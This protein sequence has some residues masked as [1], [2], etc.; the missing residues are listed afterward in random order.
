MKL[1]ARNLLFFLAIIT[2]TLIPTIFF[3]APMQGILSTKS[4]ML[5]SNQF[6]LVSFYIHVILGGIAL[7]I[8]W[9][10]FVDKIRNKYLNFHKISGRIYVGCFLITAL[11]SILVSYH[12]MGGVVSQLGFMSV[13]AIAVFTTWKGYTAI[14]NKK[15]GEHQAWMRYSYA[16]CLAS[17][18]L[19]L[20]SPLLGVIVEDGLL[21]YRIVAWLAWVPN[22]IV[23]YFINKRYLTLNLNKKQNALLASPRIKEM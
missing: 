15:I 16:C 4:A 19:R 10:G 13:G 23:V 11:T 20:W 17:V 5:L 12:S 22:L 2:A 1:F 7:L 18:T 9:V 14:V 8:G 21:V 3:I 6:Y